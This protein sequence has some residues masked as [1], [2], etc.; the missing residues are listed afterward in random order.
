VIELEPYKHYLEN[1]QG[2]S[3][4]TS[5]AYCKDLT[6]F[7]TWL[8]SSA[9]KNPP[10]WL[11]V[12][13]GHIRAFLQTK[14]DLSKH[15]AHRIISSLRSFFDY[16][17]KIE[18]VRG[19]NP[20]LEISKPKLPRRLPKAMPV[21]DVSKLI[22]AAGSGSKLSLSDRNMAVIGFL[23]GSGLRIGEMVGMTMDKLE[24]SDREGVREPVAVR[25]VGKG[26]KERR[27]PLSPT[28]RRALYQW[29][30]HRRLEGRLDVPFVWVN[31]A[32]KSKGKVLTAGAVR[33]MMA[34]RANEAGLE[35]K[36]PH[37]L[38]H[39]YLMELVSAGVGI[40]VAKDIAGHASIATTQIY[41]HASRGRLEGAA[42]VLP[43]VLDVRG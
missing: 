29:L 8:D 35:R 33:Q 20:A 25:V 21:S 34:A 16:Q 5:I 17:W 22:S 31:T 12:T 3:P 10:T 15:R 42:E 23:Y 24:Y 9:K 14:K 11:E 4:Q 39:T 37:K 18:K 2:R 26:D 6:E 36:S 28:A 27:V 38:R 13:A 30:K 1:E 32:G 40:E 41:V 19:E 43:D 7:R